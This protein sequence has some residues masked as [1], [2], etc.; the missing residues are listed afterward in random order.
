MG[1]H[2]S[3]VDSPHKTPVM[4]KRSRGMPSSSYLFAA[5]CVAYQI[6]HSKTR[7]TWWRHQMETFSASLAICAGNSPVQFPAQRSVTRSC[8]V[9]FDFFDFLWFETPS[10]PLWRHCDAT[11]VLHLWTSPPAE[12]FNFGLKVR[13]PPTL[14]IGVWAYTGSEDCL[15]VSLQAEI[16][17]LFICLW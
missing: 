16:D 17:I 13:S 8:G 9:F 1:I 15:N 2:R 6:I 3:P 4:R 11:I 12:S 5:I 7:H 10:R 14:R